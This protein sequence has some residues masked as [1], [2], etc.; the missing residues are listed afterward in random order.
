MTEKAITEQYGQITKLYDALFS[1][2]FKWCCMMT[3]DEY[4]SQ[5]LV[6]EG[7]LRALDHYRD[8]D[9]LTFHQQ[10]A[11][12][13]QT[14]KHLY[15]DSL[16]RKKKEVHLEDMEKPPAEGRSF[17]SYSEAEWASVINSL[18]P[19]EGKI[20]T[21]KYSEGLTSVQIGKVLGIPPGTVRS[22]LSDARKHLKEKL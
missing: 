4:I 11:W 14:I 5:E 7:F 18:P 13:Y 19:D 6:Q 1:E 9:G 17:D 12:L 22:K 8:L 2:L 3:Q 10:R 16:R 15:I 21:L 20:L